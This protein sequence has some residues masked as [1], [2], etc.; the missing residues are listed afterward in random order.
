MISAAFEDLSQAL[1]V[2][3]E[4]HWKAYAG[5]LLLVD[6]AEAVGN[7]D[8]GLNAVL[9]AFHSLYDA[10]E[11]QHGVNP[12]DWYATPELAVILAMRN[13]RHHNKANRIRNI[14]TYHVSTSSS[15][16]QRV[17]YVLIDFP[18]EE[19][20]A[21]TF[22][23]YLS[24]SDLE[25]LLNMAS[26]ESRLRKGTKELIH[27]YLGAERFPAYAATHGVGIEKLFFNVIPLIVNA[28]RTIVPLIKTDLKP[29]STESETYMMHF[30]SVSR[31]QTDKH[32]VHVLNLALPH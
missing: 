17:K 29:I 13:A 4:A 24:W 32:E 19:D 30:G 2:L 9:H 21:D 10:I 15:P 11:K 16:T 23:I 26:E 27:R 22:E 14:Y 6:R 5:N 25:Q 8:T 20:G 1:R 18:A 28:A 12:V 7:I 3:L 31:A